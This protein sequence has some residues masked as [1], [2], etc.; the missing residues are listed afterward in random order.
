MCPYVLRS[1]LWC[2]LRYPNKDDVRFVFPS[3][4]LQEVSCLIYV[5]CIC[6]RI[7]MSNTYCVVFLVLFVFVFTLCCQFLWI[8]LF[9]YSVFSNAYLDIY[10]DLDFQRYL[11]PLFR[12]QWVKVR[13][14][15]L[16]CRYW[17]SCCPSLFKR[18][19][20]NC[21]RNKGNGTITLPPWIQG[22]ER[23]RHSYIYFKLTKTWTTMSWSIK[24]NM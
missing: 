11:S 20:H 23:G 16:S 21:H 22:K 13:G 8:V 15:Y 3:S 18:S 12:V 1:V 10:S 4:Y 7:M 2:Q 19:F 5:I 24:E 9:W 6:L 17:W 14:D